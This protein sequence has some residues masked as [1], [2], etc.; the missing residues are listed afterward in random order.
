MP[1]YER[2]LDDKNRIVFP[3]E[4]TDKWGRKV[5]IRP[6]GFISLVFPKK[7]DREHVI[8]STKLLLHELQHELEIE[9]GR[10]GE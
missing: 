10:H 4:V 5:I 9:K 6:N 8:E 1:E 3:R 7:L 2:P